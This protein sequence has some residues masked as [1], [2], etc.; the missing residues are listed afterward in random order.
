MYV[1]FLVGSKT[2]RVRFPVLFYKPTNSLIGPGAPII[3]PLVAQPP[4]EHMSDYETELVIVIGKTAKNVS[5]Q[6]A[7]DYVLGYTGSSRHFPSHITLHAEIVQAPMM[8]VI[9]APTCTFYPNFEPGFFSQTSI[10]R[11]P[12]EFL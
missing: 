5:E 3:I 12:M 9:N 11:Q 4:K 2:H 6:D 1:R 7:L 8:Y 10:C